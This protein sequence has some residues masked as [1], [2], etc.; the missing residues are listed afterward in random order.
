[1][2]EFSASPSALIGAVRERATTDEP[3][4][5]LATAVT[6]AAE[7]TTAA[8]AVVEHYIGGARAAGLSWTVIGE[9]LGVSKQAA[10]QRYASRLGHADDA[11]D[12]E[13][14]G[15]S[16][17]LTA[18]LEAAQEAADVDDSVPGTQHL[19]LGLLHTGFAA[20]VLDRLGVTRDRIRNAATRLFEPVS[21]PDGA[22]VVGDGE[23]E[24]AV[25]HARRLA[26]GRGQRQVD[27]QQVL[28]VIALDPGSAAR[29]V[30]ND[31]GVDPARMKKELADMIPPPV[32]SRSRG[33][34]IRGRVCAFCGCT[35]PDRPMVAGPGVWICANCVHLG[36]EILDPGDRVLRSG[37]TV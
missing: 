30:L 29:R 10:R 15:M 16:P 26:A 23:A 32:R 25:G 4:A 33:K 20:S 11:V 34:R 18:C 22:R 2:A 17:R 5:L 19:L 9:R 37:T 6:V 12:A 1:M 21:Q 13:G 14:I 7:A 35:D 3:L 28:F 36:V 24:V 8:D 27:T 31:L